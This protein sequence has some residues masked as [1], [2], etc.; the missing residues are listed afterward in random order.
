MIIGND[1][2]ALQNALYQACGASNPA[3]ILPGGVHRLGTSSDMLVGAVQALLALGAPIVDQWN[4]STLFTAGIGGN[5]DVVRALL[6]HESVAED[7]GQV[8]KFAREAVRPLII[9]RRDELRSAAAAPDA[10]GGGL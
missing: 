2:A 4:R 5:I 7:W 3:H 6:P 9:A 1:E 10:G 8:L